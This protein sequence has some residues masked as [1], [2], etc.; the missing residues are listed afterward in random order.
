MKL[1]TTPDPFLSKTAKPVVSWT[2]KLNKQLEQM[3]TLL[4]ASKDPQGLGLA[5]TQ[6]GINKRF[7][8][9]LEQDKVQVYINPYITKTS[10]KMLSDKYK[11]ERKRPLE[12]CLSIPKIWGFVDR[13]YQITLSYQHLQ[14]ASLKATTAKFKG[15]EAIGIQHERDHLDGILFT[16]HILNQDGTIFKETKKG[17]APLN[18]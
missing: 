11:N 4:R 8:I 12:G 15:L 16:S 2:P 13:P 14:G 7:F 5:A 10:S 17:L 3:T 9:I 1:I 18:S 6:V